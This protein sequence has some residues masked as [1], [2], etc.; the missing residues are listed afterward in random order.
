M[1]TPRRLIRVSIAAIVLLGA[2]LVASS[3]AN[4]PQAEA[5]GGCDT[6][7]GWGWCYYGGPI[8]GYSGMWALTEMDSSGQ[9]T[10]PCVYSS[11]KIGGSWYP[12]ATACEVPYGDGDIG[13]YAP[14][15]TCVYGEHWVQDAVN[16]SPARTTFHCP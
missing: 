9:Y 7:Q 8:G 6:F 11:F 4:V 16:Q 3:Q 10:H 12:E 2:G 15:A 13:K 14:T 1:K 5:G